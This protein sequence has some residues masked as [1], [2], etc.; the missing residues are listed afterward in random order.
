YVTGNGPRF[1]TPHEIRWMRQQGGD[2]VGMTAGTEAILMR[3]AG[4]AYANAS[5]VTNLG[6]GLS[7][8]PITDEEVQEVMRRSGKRVLDL[9]LEAAR[10][11]LEVVP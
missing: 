5:F 3:E 10:L 1:E 8:T 9:M 2:V 11:A 6:C 4:I 7:T